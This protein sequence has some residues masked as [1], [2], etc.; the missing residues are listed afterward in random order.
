MMPLLALGTGYDRPSPK[1]L[2]LV[3]MVQQGLAMGYAHIETAEIYPGFASIGPALASVL[4][5]S[6]SARS[7]MEQLV[8]AV[9]N[10][11]FP[12]S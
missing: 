9:S 12:R 2:S 5:P 1:G 10:A 3:Q 4:L 8:A 6:P 11:F 7:L